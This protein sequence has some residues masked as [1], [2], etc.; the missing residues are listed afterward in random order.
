MK[1][2]LVGLTLLASMSSFAN[3]ENYKCVSST[4]SLV[5]SDVIA[6][7][8]MFLGG[9]N[10]K[11]LKCAQDIVLVGDSGRLYSETIDLTTHIDEKVAANPSDLSIAINSMTIR[12]QDEINELVGQ[13]GKCK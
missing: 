5:C 12:I 2:L 13:Y 3:I 4:S 7:E 10:V 1:K 11:E 9:L 6:T 8:G